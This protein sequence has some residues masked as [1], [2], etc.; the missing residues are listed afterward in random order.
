MVG[1]VV[2][3]SV[4]NQLFAH[5]VL[6][7]TRYHQSSNFYST[8]TRVWNYTHTHQSNKS[9]PTRFSS[10]KCVSRSSLSSSSPGLL[11][12][13]IVHKIT[14]T[15]TPTVTIKAR[16]YGAV[17]STDTNEAEWTSWVDS[18]AIPV[19]TACV[20]KSTQKPAAV[21]GTWGT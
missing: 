8:F 13:R 15:M 6:C 16:A 20:S 21:S 14:A 4:P 9:L 10:P 19:P 12:M 5:D 2:N 3:K 11:T 18:T 17:W 1:H 7:E